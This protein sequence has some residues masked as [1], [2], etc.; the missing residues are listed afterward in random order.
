M[1][2]LNLFKVTPLYAGLLG[3]LY[4]AL[5]TLVIRGRWKFK[6]GIGTGG[7]KEMARLVRVHGNFSE[8]VPLALLLMCLVEIGGAS[9]MTLHIIGGMLFIGRLAHAYG[10]YSHAGTSPGRFIGV[11]C[12]FTVIIWCSIALL[13]KSL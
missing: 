8:Y 10:L 2:M 13:I 9:N 4:I 3:L 12:T 11:G 1:G 6:T 7:N 5:S